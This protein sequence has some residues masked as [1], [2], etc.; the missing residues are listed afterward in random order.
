MADID[1]LTRDTIA[2]GG[3]LSW[4]YFD[5]HGSSK[6]MLNEMGAG[7]INKILK[8]PGVVYA[9]GEIQEPIEKE[10]LFSTTVQIKVLTKE[11]A[12]LTLLCANYSPFS[13][14]I[15]KPDKIDLGIDKAH[16]L[17]M[18]IA[19]TTYEYK[20]YILQKVAKPEDLEKYKK[21]LENK[22]ELGKRILGKKEEKKA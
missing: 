17:L 16:E 13:V 15:L 7:F 12:H 4:L 20:K 14:E 1:K 5:L 2:Q 3:V 8:S 21:S 11:F 19:T 10:G 9:L 6:D 22:V 18:Q